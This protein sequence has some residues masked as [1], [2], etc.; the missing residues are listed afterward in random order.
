M[1]ERGGEFASY[2]SD[3]HTVLNRIET[4]ASNRFNYRPL[5]KTDTK[6]EM[7]DFSTPPPRFENIFERP[8]AT[9]PF[10]EAQ[11]SQPM[12]DVSIGFAWQCSCDIDLMVTASRSAPPLYYANMETRDGRFLKDYTTTNADFGFETVEFSRPIRI[13][14][15]MISANLYGAQAPT[16]VVAKVRISIGDET[17]EAPFKITART[18]NGGEGRQS[19][20]RNR[21]APNSAWTIIDPVAILTGQ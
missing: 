14:Q 11:L 15:I 10:S 13:D 6:L 21:T 8:L 12:E 4:G 1:T 3:I 7:V 2:E 18:G 19:V 17:Y 9:R 16:D 5:S 20:I